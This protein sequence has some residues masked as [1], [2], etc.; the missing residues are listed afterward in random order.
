MTDGEE[1][2]GLRYVGPATAPQLAAAGISPTD[3]RERGVSF[4]RLRD[5]G[6]NAGVAARIRR[7]YSLPWAFETEPETDLA[8]RSSQIRGLN[9]GERAWVAASSGDWEAAERETTDEWESG[10]TEPTEAD[11]S[12][13]PIAAESAW[14]SRSEPTGVEELD[15]VDEELRQ[16]LASAGVT[17]VRSLAATDPEALA[18]ALGLETELVAELK[19]AAAHE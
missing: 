17:S 4:Q 7:E 12:G 19:S 10:V 16:L 15:G 11:G 3:I 2:E 18:D 8:H 9:E 13:D 1:L 14:Q 6:V 5:A